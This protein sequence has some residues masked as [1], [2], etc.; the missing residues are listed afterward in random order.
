[1]LRP[2]AVEE[3]IVAGGGTALLYSSRGLKALA[4][5]T[6]NFD[7]KHGIEI[8]QR[9]LTVTSFPHPFL[10]PQAHLHL[11]RTFILRGQPTRSRTW[12]SP[13]TKS[14]A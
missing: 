14:E 1:M 10:T 8:M 12:L 9:A 7:Q 4:E 11:E 2:Q 6:K 3:G 13:V 5:E